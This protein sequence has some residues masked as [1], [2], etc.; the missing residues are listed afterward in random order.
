MKIIVINRKRLGVTVIIIGL[1]MILFGVESKFDSRL[2]QTALMHSNLNSLKTY[3]GLDK[4]F[5]YQLPDQWSTSQQVFGGNEILYHNDFISEDQ[6]IYGFVQV[7]NLKGD[8]RAFIESGRQHPYK[9]DQLIGYSVKPEKINKHDGYHVEYTVRDRYGNNH[10]VN[11]YYVGKAEK[12]FRFSFSVREP[13]FKENMPA[14]FKAIASTM[15]YK[16][17]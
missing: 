12:V 13:N 6:K 11:E 3:E 7:W 14:V 15:E 9:P 10:K 17:Q 5:A 2:K 16:G 8:L 4:A 1:M